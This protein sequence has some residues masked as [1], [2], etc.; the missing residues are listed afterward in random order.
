MHC[1]VT[2][3]I[4]LNCSTSATKIMMNLAKSDR[5]SQRVGSE[6]KL[7]PIIGFIQNSRLIHVDISPF[8]S[9]ETLA[10]DLQELLKKNG[11]SVESLEKAVL[12]QVRVMRVMLM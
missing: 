8:C 10:P 7:R 9:A 5:K 2:L 4:I 1:N 12:M 6:G 11:L 3:V